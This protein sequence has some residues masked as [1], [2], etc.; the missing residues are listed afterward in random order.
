MLPKSRSEQFIAFLLGLARF[1]SDCAE[2]VDKHADLL[3]QSGKDVEQFKSTVCQPLRSDYTCDL[4]NGLGSCA[5]TSTGYN[6]RIPAG[7]ITFDKEFVRLVNK[8]YARDFEVFGY[9][10]INITKINITAR[11]PP[12]GPRPVGQ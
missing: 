4:E 3:R 1:A 8:Y 11:P 5:P 6:S 7:G 2:F 9:K 12:P 10:M